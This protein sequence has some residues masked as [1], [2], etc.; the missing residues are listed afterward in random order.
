MSVE[1]PVIGEIRKGLE[2][3]QRPQRPFMWANCLDCG[4]TRWVEVIGGIPRT[5]RCPPCGKKWRTRER[6]SIKNKDDSDYALTTPTLGEVRT[7]IEIG[8][9]DGAKFIWAACPDC[10]EARWVSLV[11]IRKNG[12]KPLSLRCRSCEARRRIGV[13]NNCWRGGKFTNG[14]GYIE[15]Y[16]KPDNPFFSMSRGRNGVSGY[17]PEHRLVMAQQL[18]RCLTT[19]ENVH[20]KNGIRTDN[21]SE[22][23]QLVTLGAHQGEVV[24]PFCHKEFGIR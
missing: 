12:G 13:F 14:M 16:V 15:I 1:T 10:Q 3:G 5:L 17:I 18:G 24:C 20:H 2:I 11:D 7:S 6:L 21:R 23:L 22:N 8:R 9:G 19:E 4:K